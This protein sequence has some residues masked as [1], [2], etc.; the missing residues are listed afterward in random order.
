MRALFAAIILLLITIHLATAHPVPPPPPFRT[1]TRVYVVKPTLP[2]LSPAPTG[3]VA[4]RPTFTP[5][6]K[7]DLHVI[8]CR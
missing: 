2:P 7:C 1:P 3:T 5:T 6:P 8:P 4:P